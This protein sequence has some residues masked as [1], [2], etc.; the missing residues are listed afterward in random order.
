MSGDVRRIYDRIANYE[1]ISGDTQLKNNNSLISV[2]PFQF[3][4]ANYKNIKSRL[5]MPSGLTN[6]NRYLEHRLI[7]LISF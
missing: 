5:T 3:V 6:Q 7:P 2:A 1:R 4:L